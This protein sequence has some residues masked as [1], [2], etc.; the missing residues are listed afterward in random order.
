MVEFVYTAAAEHDDDDDDDKA[1]AILKN[2]FHS[3]LCN[4][5]DGYFEGRQNVDERKG[6]RSSTSLT[7]CMHCWK[8]L[9]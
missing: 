3:D 9:A 5:L 1:F 7:T 2:M 6:P 8:I 4:V